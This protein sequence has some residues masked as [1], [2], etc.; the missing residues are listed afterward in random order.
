MVDMSRLKWFGVPVLVFA[1]VGAAATYYEPSAATFTS[2]FLVGCWLAVTGLFVR[3]L[4]RDRA[5]GSPQDKIEYVWGTAAVATLFAAWGDYTTLGAENLLDPAPAFLNWWVVVT[6]LPYLSWNLAL[7]FACVHKYFF[8]HAGTRAASSRKVAAF[9]ASCLLAFGIVYYT[10]T[11]EHGPYLRPTHDLPSVALLVQSICSVVVL[12]D[13]FA[14]RRTPTVMVARTS[15]REAARR[16]R[17]VDAA[18]RPAAQPAPRSARTTR[19]STTSTPAR[20]VPVTEARATSRGSPRGI[21]VVHPQASP[22]TSTRVRRVSRTVP[23]P[24]QVGATTKSS[25]AQSRR[26]TPDTHVTQ[27]GRSRKVDMY[28]S[29]RPKTG[30]LSQEDFKCIFCF[31]DFSPGERDGVVICP[32]CKY[33]AHAS[34]FK[35][36]LRSSTLCSRCG[37]E[38]PV[39]FR[40]SPRVVPVAEYLA[41]MNYLLKKR[42]KA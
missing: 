11:R 31:G 36:W 4:K 13:L 32:R 16:V 39:A 22:R 26:A 27:M 35:D 24:S 37:A 34:E 25:R 18:S 20:S 30:V 33:P 19:R 42:K 5:Y 41:A 8:V 9:T 38:L 7:L 2:W 14:T 15:P 3:Q 12:A 29:W 23:R 21:R 17:A 28:D 1:A 6:A 10:A 40:V